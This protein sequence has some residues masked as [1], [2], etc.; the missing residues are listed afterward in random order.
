MTQKTQRIKNAI[1]GLFIADAMSMPAHWYYKLEFLKKDFNGA[2]TGYED[3]QHPHP[4]SF[5]V[6]MS[7]QPDIEKAKALGRPYDILHE[8]CR[9]YNTSYDQLTIKTAVRGGEHA[10]AMPELKDRYHYHH[11]LKKG[12]N[13]LGANLVRV[14]MR[15]VIRK[16]EYQQAAFIEDFID[17]L[18]TEGKNNDPYC[19]IYI[20]AWFENY[21]KGLPPHAC[22]EQQSNV[23]SIGS[24]GGI[25]RPLL[26][27]LIS[28]S[29]Y[30]GLG[31]ALEHQQITHRSENIGSA[32]AVLV[33]L[34]HDLVNGS[35][36][37]SILKKYAKKIQLIK[38]RGEE[39]S[40]TYFDHK[41]PGNIPKDEMWKIH[42][43]YSDKQLDLDELINDYP[44][45][46]V[47]GKYFA[48]AC[49]PEHGV[50]LFMYQLY[51]NKFDF[52]KSILANANAGGDNVHRGMIAG[53]LAGAASVDIPQD[54]KE[55]LTEYDGLENEIIAFVEMI[56]GF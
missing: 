33:P 28:G 49:Y 20:R 10:N 15:S 17:H 16:G 36:A 40:R 26:L 43:D 23:W 54:L 6:G 56:S 47:I 7:Y 55:G 24:M 53:L 18:A 32:L 50:P 14:L 27:S 51:K 34:L 30:E 25:I 35:D 45:E 41:G 52:K 46:E 22:A 31:V 39:L 9:F 44:D 4:E 42:T 29:A 3:A 37:V 19:E 5:M 12:D 8:H 13:T 1:W 11:G 38:I 2:I 48:T 21:S